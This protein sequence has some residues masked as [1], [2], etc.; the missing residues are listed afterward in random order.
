MGGRVIFNDIA[1]WETHHFKVIRQ[2]PEAN[3]GHITHGTTHTMHLD[4]TPKGDG[5]QRATS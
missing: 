3:M 2:V 5:I 4:P 1:D